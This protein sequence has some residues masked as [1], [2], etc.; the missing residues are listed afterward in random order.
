VMIVKGPGKGEW[1]TIVSNTATQLVVD[2]DWDVVHTTSTE[3]VLLGD[4]WKSLGACG[5]T[6]PV[7]SVLVSSKAVVYFA[8]GDSVNIRRMRAFD[9]AGTWRDFNDA[10]NCQAD[11]S[12]NMAEFLIEA[13]RQAV[14]YRVQNTD[15]NGDVSCSSADP[16]DWGTDLDFGTEAPLGSRD[17]TA[18]GVIIYEDA[19][20][21][22]ALV[23][24]KTDI[25]WF[26]PSTGD[27]Y[28]MT[29]Q[30]MKTIR[31]DK[32][33]RASLRHDVY[34]YFSFGNGWEQYYNGQLN[35]VGPNRDEGL[36]D[37]RS[38]PVTCSLGYPG[39]YYIG[40]DAGDNG[41]SS[42]LESRWHELYR[43]PK[44]QRVKALAFQ[45]IPGDVPDRMWVWMNNMIIWLPFPVDM[46]NETKDPNYLFTDE[47]A[48]EF[49][50]MH[51]GLL[52]T[53]KLAKLVKVVGENLGATCWI[54]MDYRVDTETE[55]NPLVDKFDDWP[56]K[57]VLLNE[58]FGVAGKRIMLR[59]RFYTEDASQTPTMEA[60]ILE[61]VSRV[62]AK[63][64]YSATCLIADLALDL[65]SDPD[66]I[67]EAHKKQEQLDLWAGDQVDSV[68][69]MRSINPL[70][71]KKYVFLEP[72]IAQS[73][74]TKS[75][76]SDRREVNSFLVPLQLRDA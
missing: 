4:K 71:D 29:L 3:Y 42:V 76:P 67:Q 35:D 51:A 16:Q 55:W 8:M 34:L 50:R 46:V 72:F 20:G 48:L 11:D 49:S 47:G 62:A 12:T 45:V 53:Q 59:A 36:P 73:L 17:R 61:A 63:H 23:V 24:Y 43:C 37:E 15:A 44:G 6:A 28:E 26:V 57:E 69:L 18:T 32:N 27:P 70:Y 33:G 1:R 21:Y 39:K 58:Q 64:I 10:S 60:M 38:G 25:P 65:N 22:E 75:D 52:D 7:T 14:I 31:G 9:D 19:G 5:L 66:D 13:P 41:Y 68:L 2:V 40:V 30:E 54:E 56:L 74:I